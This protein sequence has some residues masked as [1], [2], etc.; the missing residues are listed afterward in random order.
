MPVGVLNVIT[1][2]RESLTRERRRV[3]GPLP[4]YNR[5]GKRCGGTRNAAGATVGSRADAVWRR[6]AVGLSC[7]PMVPWDGR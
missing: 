4:L 2:I 7:A 6:A 1:Y 5:E 3:S